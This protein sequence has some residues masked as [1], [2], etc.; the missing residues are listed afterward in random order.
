VGGER[1]E[2]VFYYEQTQKPRLSDPRTIFCFILAFYFYYI[3]II[4]R[5]L[6]LPVRVSRCIN[7]SGSFLCVYYTVEE[8]VVG[9]EEEKGKN[10]FD[11]MV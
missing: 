1:E 8:G 3:I 4:I 11:G 7:C 5:L 2:K 10:P 6:L 9:E